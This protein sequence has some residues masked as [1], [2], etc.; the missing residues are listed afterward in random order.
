MIAQGHILHVTDQETWEALGPTGAYVPT[1]Y[2]DEGFIHCCDAGQL[3]DVLERHFQDTTEVT[4][5]VVDPSLLTADVRY[6]EGYPGELFPHIYGPI[7]T[8]AVVSV[9]SVGST[10]GTWDLSVLG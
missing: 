9:I 10:D 6:E 4:L 7:E 1:A 5:L 8:A 2:D 3:V